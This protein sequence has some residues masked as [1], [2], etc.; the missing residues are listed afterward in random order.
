MPL[1]YLPL[2]LHFYV[3]STTPLCYSSNFHFLFYLYFYLVRMI[4][5]F[6]SLSSD[7]NEFS[8]NIRSSLSISSFK[9]F[10]K[11]H[12]YSVALPRLKKFLFHFPIFFMFYG[13]ISLVPPREQ[14]LWEV[15]EERYIK[16]VYLSLFHSL[17]KQQQQKSTAFL[18]SLLKCAFYIPV[19]SIMFHIL[20]LSHIF[21]LFCF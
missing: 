8:W 4:V 15:S 19:L 12:F 2:V 10:P 18:S 6:Q 21:C 13:L 16:T 9:S 14:A 5:H 7:W 17:N 11:S 3:A 20:F 1:T